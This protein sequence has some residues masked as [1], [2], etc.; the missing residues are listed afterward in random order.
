MH[1]T[2]KGETTEK[3]NLNCMPSDSK[4]VIQICHHIDEIVS[5]RLSANITPSSRAG[6]LSTAATSL[7]FSEFIKLSH[8]N[9]H[10]LTDVLFSTTGN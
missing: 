2:E 9:I 8:L 6:R 5:L 4:S 1:P 3:I 7:V 10:V